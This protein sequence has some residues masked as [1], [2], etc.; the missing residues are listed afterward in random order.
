MPGHTY[1]DAVRYIVGGADPG[2]DSVSEKVDPHSSC[3]ILNTRRLF[4][5]AAKRWLLSDTI[6]LA[7]EDKMFEMRYKEEK[8]RWGSVVRIG[9]MQKSLPFEVQAV[10]FGCFLNPRPGSFRLHHQGQPRSLHRHRSIEFNAENLKRVGT[11]CMP[12]HTR[13][14][15]RI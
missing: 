5:L 3:L 9:R 7:L 1:L 13:R 2:G 15:F 10:Q 12:I 4:D 14:R 8:G 11:L 6:R